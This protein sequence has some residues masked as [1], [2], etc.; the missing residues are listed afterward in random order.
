MNSKTEKDNI[1]G[2]KTPWMDVRAEWNRQRKS[3]WTQW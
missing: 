1:L 3:Q 2:V